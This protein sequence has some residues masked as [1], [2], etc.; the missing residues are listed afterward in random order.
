MPSGVSVSTKV[1]HCLGVFKPEETSSRS[2]QGYIFTKLYQTTMGSV[3]P[4]Y[5]IGVDVGGT[6]TD[7]VILDPNGALWENRGVIAFHKTAT[8]SPNVTNGIESAVRAVIEQCQVSLGQIRSI[9]IGTTHFINA[10]VE[11]DARQLSKVAVIRLSTSY[12]RD[13]P[14][15]SDFPP[16]LAKLMN[17]YYG[18]VNGGLHIDGSQE[19]PV[20]RE[21][22]IQQCNIIKGKGLNTVVICG[23][24]SPIDIHFRQ[25][26]Q[27]RKII[28]EQ[29]PDADV[30]CSFEVA[31]MG[32]LERENASILNASILKFARRTIRGFKGA[33]RRLRL[34]CPLYLTQNDGTLIEAAAA[35]RLPIRT[36][37]SGAT[38][39]MRGAAYLGLSSSKGAR[40]LS[41]MVIDIGG[42]TSDVG[43]LL[44][45]GYPRQASAFVTVAGIKINYN[46][47]HVESIGLGGGSIVTVSE[48]GNISV[49]PTSV[50]Y[51]LA[52]ESKVFNG[53]TLT[54][55]DI[56][57]AHDPALNIG[58]PTLVQDIPTETITLA[59]RKIKTMLERVIDIMKT[60]PEPLPVLLVGGGSAIAPEELDGASTIIRPPFHQVA[61]AVGAAI[62]KAGSTIDIIQGTANQTVS[63]ALELAKQA[64]IDAAITMGAIRQSIQVTEMESIPLQ[65]VE[66]QI[67]TVVPVAG[68]L[69]T[70]MTSADDS[71]SHHLYYADDE[72]GD[73]SMLVESKLKSGVEDVPGVLD[74][75]SYRPKV[76]KN[77]ETGI[78]EWI[79]SETDLIWLADGCYV[80]GCAG[81]GTPLPEFLKL[82]DQV[83]AGHIIR[84]VDASSMTKDAIIY[85]GGNMGSPAV[86]AERLS[87][88]ELL[89]CIDEMM[90]YLR[91]NT[92][93]AVMSVEIGGANGLQPLLWGSSKNYNRVCL[94]ADLMGE[95]FRLLPPY[96][97]HSTNI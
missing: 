66:H 43:V 12:T 24:F 63:E 45:S 41:A 93:D 15:F 19:S 88:G 77:T 20:V 80:L 49:G 89:E 50:G 31:N 32:F 18:Y 85:W 91:H 78:S 81:G 76:I 46:M 96:L 94:D 13:I 38:N 25:E 10:V 55:T 33:M 67:R 40:N 37:S 47:P 53:D 6:N 39:S 4:S 90:Y 44:P 60:S 29:M 61:N 65:Y 86:S 56:A 52:T 36:F 87:A 1:R 72:D 83:R 95:D 28:L 22:V 70:D 26:H 97:I 68:D 79:I 8:T 27:V 23:V 73:E 16:A 7:A 75:E 57:F 21:Q 9:C 30:V 17:G 62:S 69:S 54:A 71:S 5:R 74:I 2:A 14:P 59:R 58:N 92:F 48:D 3:L 11:H 82:R 84:V 64:A 42:T 51:R 35:A 34:D